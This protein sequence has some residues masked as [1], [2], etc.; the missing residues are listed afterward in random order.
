VAAVFAA[1]AWLHLAFQ[2]LMIGASWTRLRL[3]D[4]TVREAARPTAA[5][6]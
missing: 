1:L 5:D 3:D 6:S 2:V 4:A